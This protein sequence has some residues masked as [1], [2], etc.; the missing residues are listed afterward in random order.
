MFLLSASFF[1]F[2]LSWMPPSCQFRARDLGRS[3][4][5]LCCSSPFGPP[6]FTEVFRQCCDVSFSFLYRFPPS[7]LAFF[8]S[9]P[10]RSVFGNVLGPGVL[11]L[12]LFLS[13]RFSSF[14]K[15]PRRPGLLKLRA[16]FKQIPP[17]FDFL[18]PQQFTLSR[19]SPPKSF[20]Y[21]PFLLPSRLTLSVGDSLVP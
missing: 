20:L 15:G 11:T 7:H 3:V 10:L 5:Y 17:Y 8:P 4:P 21:S 16:P 13:L 9:S 14:L 1:Y 18:P 12:R 6:F 19:R 2:F